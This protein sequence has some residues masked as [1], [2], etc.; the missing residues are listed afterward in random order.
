MGTLRFTSYIDRPVP[1]PLD[2]GMN[3]RVPVSFPNS[4]ARLHAATTGQDV[5]AVLGSGSVVEA[6]HDIYLE[7][8][9]FRRAPDRF[10]RRT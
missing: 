8:R 4:W 7:S 9:P 1:Q 6:D 3:S 2:P 5:S 10:E